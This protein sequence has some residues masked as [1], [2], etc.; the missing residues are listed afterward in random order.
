MTRE[1]LKEE[2]VGYYRPPAAGLDDYGNWQVLHLDHE[3]MP[4]A[5][6]M[7]WNTATLAWEKTTGSLTG[8]GTVSVNNFPASFNVN[9]TPDP[10]ATVLYED[11]TTMYACKAAIGS[12][13]AS[14]VWQIRK[15]VTASGVVITWCDGNASYDNTATN[16]ATVQGHSYS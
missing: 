9:V 10:K 14:A 1:A 16:L 8:G 4:Y 3:G 13:L 11:G 12:A 15:I 6:N 2:Q 5:K 7:I